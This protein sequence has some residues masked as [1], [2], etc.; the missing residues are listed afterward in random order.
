M[1]DNLYISTNNFKTK[2]LPEILE[3]CLKYGLYNLELGSNIEYNEK[4]AEI[5]LNYAGNPFKFII[6][7]YFPKKPT[8]LV[9]NLASS[10]KDILK[11]SIECCKTAIDLS[12]KIKAPLYSFHAGYAID[13]K[14]QDLG[15]E[16]SHL[17]RITLNGAYEIFLDSAKQLL[18]YAGQ[19][20]MP[21]IVENNVIAPFNLI[22]G[23]NETLLLCNADEI[24]RFISDTDNKI[25][26]LIDMGHLYV[27]SQSL[28]IDREKMIS[29]L[30]QFAKA[31]HLSHN[32]GYSDQHLSFDE[33]VWFA[34]FLRKN[35][36]KIFVVEAMGLDID[37][38]IK[39]KNAIER[40]MLNG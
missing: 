3:V 25:G 14:P 18:Q 21:I 40:I 5:A 19:K 15:K 37:E 39:C 1:M 32:D 8:S 12:A 10:N 26:L 6:H 33:N 34:K 4:N 11:E 22:D 27:T 28:K 29:D 16:L 2:N 7:H 38:L 20:N 35:N 13:P 24:R 31:F 30:L 36:D 9:L 17:S 23:K